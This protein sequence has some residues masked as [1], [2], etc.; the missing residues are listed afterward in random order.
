MS[1]NYENPVDDR[2]IDRLVDGELEESE[3]QRL[4]ARLENEPG[5]W[6]R[7]ALAFLE[8]QAWTRTFASSSETK[9]LDSDHPDMITHHLIHSGKPANP[10][11]PRQDSRRRPVQKAGILAAGILLAFAAGWIANGASGPFSPTPTPLSVYGVAELPKSS[12]G[13]KPAVAESRASTV[14][15]DLEPA[16]PARLPELE[17]AGWQTETSLVLTEPV[18]RELERRGYHVQER[19]GLVS[20]ELKN[21]QSLAVPVDEVEL[22][23]VGNRTY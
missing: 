1:V 19:S 3:R 21:G 18:R 22:H 5:G 17:E 2:W 13:S 16:E 8:A 20:M 15:R 6:R 12:N 9:A 4:L 23:Y 14:Q 11:R 7:C 10:I